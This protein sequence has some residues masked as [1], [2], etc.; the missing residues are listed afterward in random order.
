MDIKEKLEILKSKEM[1]RKEFLKYSLTIALAAVG[2]TSLLH[3]LVGTHTS[4][5]GT[6]AK[7]PEN[8][9]S[10]YGASAYGR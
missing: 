1:D 10:A 7:V 2:V 4:L 8:A 9:S 3:T 5:T 6:A